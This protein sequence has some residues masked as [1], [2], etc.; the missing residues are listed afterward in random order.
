VAG[1]RIESC[2]RLRLEGWRGLRVGGFRGLRVGGFR[3][4]RV[5]G[6]RGLRVGG[7]RGGYPRT[8]MTPSAW[9]PSRTGRWAKGRAR[10]VSACT[11]H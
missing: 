1:Y 8:R 11:G 9:P 4:L 6:F 7:W 3:G 10:P 2:R 5:G